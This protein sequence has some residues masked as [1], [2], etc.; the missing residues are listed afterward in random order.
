MDKHQISRIKTILQKSPVRKIYKSSDKKIFIEEGQKLDDIYQILDSITQ[1]DSNPINIVVMGEV[2][3]GKSTVINALVGKEVS[4]MDVLEATALIHEMIYDE[5]ESFDVH[6]LDGR[7][8]TVFSHDEL[9]KILDNES[10]KKDEEQQ[11]SKIVVKLPLD[12]LK[13]I[14]IVDTPGLQTITRQNSN[15]TEKYM[16]NADAILWVLNIH[17]N[18]QEDVTDA[19]ESSK[20]FGKPL[21]GLINRLDELEEDWDEVMN[22]MEDE[23][24][25][26]FK[27]LFPLSARTSW[28]GI[29]QNNPQK[30]QKGNIL[31]VADYLR[32]QIADHST[33]FIEETAFKTLETQIATDIG[34]HE[35]ISS[36]IDRAFQKMQHEWQ[37]TVEKN[38]R[39]KT[40][41]RSY[42]ENTIKEPQFGNRLKELRM[43]NSKC[44]FENYTN[45]P[46]F[47]SIVELHITNSYDKA[48]K[49]VVDEWVRFADFII[50]SEEEINLDESAINIQIQDRFEVVHSKASNHNSL[51]NDGIFKMSLATLVSSAMLASIAAPPLYV[52]GI[53]A[54]GFVLTKNIF[55]GNKNKEDNA[56]VEVLSIIDEI[57][58]NQIEYLYENLSAYSDRFEEKI[59][60]II[61]SYYFGDEMKCSDFLELKEDIINYCSNVKKEKMK[62]Y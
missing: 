58:L 51:D 36:K 33:E 5:Y 30:I 35:G 15:L 19:I 27:K 17:H 4:R 16:I 2:K 42:L 23:I 25:Y 21:L 20:S 56:R 47:R 7:I 31:S 28:E 50:E 60:E 39:I 53:M 43:E 40:I 24:G 8:I 52:F 34:I 12:I 49:Y 38:Q 26:L 48:A 22:H 44:T 46:E 55:S 57:K 11:V 54:G 3:A 10:L 59:K 13:K 62:H 29:I 18:G 14:H 9:H 1:V 6:Y 45:L 61:S 41:L 37:K 32:E